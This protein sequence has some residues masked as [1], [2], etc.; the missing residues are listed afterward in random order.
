MKRITKLLLALLLCV[1]SFAGYTHILN[2]EETEENVEENNIEET[3]VPVSEEVNTPSEVEGTDIVEEDQDVDTQDVV[4]ALQPLPRSGGNFETDSEGTW[5][6]NED[7]G[8]K[9]AIL[10]YNPTVGWKAGIA[11]QVKVTVDFEDFNATGKKIEV[12]IPK[13][14]KYTSYDVKG[15]PTNGTPEKAMTGVNDGLITNSI[16]PTKN[17]YYDSYYGSLIYEVK[18]ND[19]KKIEFSVNVT[20]DVTTYYGPKTFID[21]IQVSADKNGSNIGNVGVDVNA[22]GS[23]EYKITYATGNANN[24][25]GVSNS[26]ESLDHMSISVYRA[27][28]YYGIYQYF[29]NAD[30]E[31]Y[32]PKEVNLVSWSG[33]LV[34]KDENIGYLKFNIQNVVSTGTGYRGIKFNLSGVGADVYTA[35]QAMKG[36]IT[37]YDGTVIEVDYS[38]PISVTAV[39]ESTITNTLTLAGNNMTYVKVSDDFQIMGPA[40]IISNDLLSEK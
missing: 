7:G 29:K 25:T 9:V 33:G 38:T 40:F 20:P 3:D 27:G 26:N 4:G 22:T 28:E 16:N 37:M 19:S 21:G 24:V 23:V 1:T 2:A 39:D 11:Y 18:D 6:V 5:W 10:N 12:K 31:Y 36:T 17:A 35:A 15:T 8:V 30:L 32:Y 34:E 14:L 13:G